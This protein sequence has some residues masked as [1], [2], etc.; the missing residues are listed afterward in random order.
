MRVRMM[1]ALAALGEEEVDDILKSEGNI[2]V[3]PR[4]CTAPTGGLR[5]SRCTA[6]CK[7][8][9][10][11]LDHL[12]A[13]DN[14]CERSTYYLVDNLVLGCTAQVTCDLCNSTYVFTESN[15]GEI[16]SLADELGR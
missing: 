9:A 13:L 4:C 14:A 3:G 11:L 8:H 15:R 7:G 2:E 1:K 6:A 16:F 10:C 5:G 12:A